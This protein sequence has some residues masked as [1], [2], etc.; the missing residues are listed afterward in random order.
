MDPV[1]RAYH[2]SEELLRD[3]C[4][5]LIMVAPVK[6]SPDAK[7]Y[8]GVSFA[9]YTVWEFLC[10]ERI[11]N[12]Q[13]SSF[14]MTDETVKLGCTKIMLLETINNRSNKEMESLVIPE[15]CVLKSPPADNFTAYSAASSIISLNNWG[16]I[17]ADQNELCRLAFHTLD[18]SMPHFQSLATVAQKLNQNDF[19]EF[20]SISYIHQFWGLSLMKIPAE[21]TNIPLLINLLYADPTCELAQKLLEG[22]NLKEAMQTHLECRIRSFPRISETEAE[23]MFDFEGTVIELFAQLANDLPHPF[24][25]LLEQGAQYIDP[26]TILLFFIGSHG[27]S[28]S[29]KTCNDYCL[30]SRLLE[31]GANVNKSGHWV[32]P[33]QIAVGCFDLAGVKL[34]LEAGV[35]PNGIGDSNGIEWN[36]YSLLGRFKHLHAASPLRICLDEDMG[37]NWASVI[38][39]HDREKIEAELLKY[40]A[41]DFGD[42]CWSDL[43]GM[44]RA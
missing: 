23:D 40:G 34:L 5:C 44:R 38:I 8:L 26:S 15:N 12:S 35:D 33:L 36:D 14:A 37:V 20:S 32:T 13:A 31:L 9:H 10:S 43:K 19:F 27:H 42:I 11:W 6:N 17:I 25:A 30:L 24:R 39:D 16:S 28:R 3:L 2:Y 41:T 21:S 1:R 29:G 4:G 18:P 7:E 22:S